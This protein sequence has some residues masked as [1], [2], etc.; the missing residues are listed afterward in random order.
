[1]SE[2]YFS[3][4]EFPEY[5]GKGGKSKFRWGRRFKAWLVSHGCEAVL[6]SGFLASLP[7]TEAERNNLNPAVAEEKKQIDAFDLNHKA[8]DWLILAIENPDLFDMLRHELLCEEAGVGWPNGR[9]PKLWKRIFQEEN[10]EDID[11]FETYIKIE[12]AVNDECIASNV[13]E[14]KKA[15]KT[16]VQLDSQVLAMEKNEETKRNDFD[17][18]TKIVSAHVN[19]SSGKNTMEQRKCRILSARVKE[20]SSENNQEQNK[21]GIGSSHAKRFCGESNTEQH[22]LKVDINP[23]TLEMAQDKVICVEKD[24]TESKMMVHT[25]AIVEQNG[26]SLNFLLEQFSPI[27]SLLEVE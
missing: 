2:S 27:V 21:S 1:M 18:V 6:E 13:R 4:S 24:S 20:S 22:L 8:R 17:L 23:I 26:T 15:I 12:R 5:H 19:E 14:S 16:D 7:K 10:K 3:G 9:F 25:K 11:I